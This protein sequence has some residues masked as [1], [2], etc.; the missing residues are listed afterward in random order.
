MESKD[1]KKEF[2][3]MFKGNKPQELLCKGCADKLNK[4][5]WAMSYH[6]AK[7][8]AAKDKAEGATAKS[9]L[10][11]FAK[12]KGDQRSGHKYK[13]RKADGKGGWLYDYGKGFEKPKK[14]EISAQE[15]KDTPTKS[16][17]S[18][19][20]ETGEKSDAKLDLD[21]LDADIEEIAN[22]YNIH[23][24]A[25][26]LRRLADRQQAMH[27]D[28]AQSDQ[29]DAERAH[30]E[31]KPRE[32]DKL[33]TLSDKK[34]E[35][36]EPKG[37]EA[38]VKVDG[39][40]SDAERSLIE[41][42]NLEI[43]GDDKEQAALI[44]GKVKEGIEKAADVCKMSPP[45][46]KDNMGIARSDMPQL[47][48]ESFDKLKEKGQGWKV[49]AAIAAGADPDMKGTMF[50]AYLDSLKEK[51]I[52]VNDKEPYERVDVGQL[53]ATQREMQ[54][55][56]TFG[57][58]DAALKGKFDPGKNPIVISQDGF[59]L[60]GHHR[61]AAMTTIGPERKMN[62]IRVDAP[63]ETMLKESFKMQGVFRADLQ[64][65]VQVGG[66]P[67]RFKKGFVWLYQAWARGH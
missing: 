19:E 3:A 31:E 5:D 38:E 36:K 57:M 34:A 50:G 25:D 54:A 51:G 47:L 11:D 43:V 65:K 53:K 42:Y 64:D 56:K 45:V 26:V 61:F 17:L 40:V 60:D 66:T 7:D 15:K 8:K 16:D 63:M 58:A 35:G 1:G 20:R 48:D 28:A 2:D 30:G 21:A 4:G 23:N 39:D 44:A 6:H 13:S 29:E 24:V 55:D 46:C 10:L 27:D 41:D 67:E 18:A 22:K 32:R 14:E 9:L 37:K 49:D 52:K 12:A 62:V 33:A 59:I